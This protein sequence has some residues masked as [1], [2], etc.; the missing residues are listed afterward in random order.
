MCC[1]GFLTGK[2]DLTD[3]SCRNR[4]VSGEPLVTCTT[5]RV[6][7]LDYKVITSTDGIVCEKNLAFDLKDVKPTLAATDVACQGVQYKEC[8]L[9]GVQ[10][11]CFPTRMMAV[12]CQINK[13]YI[14]MRR[15]QIQR[16]VGDN[17][18]PKVEQWLG[19]EA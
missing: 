1:N 9:N 19:C 6:D 4:T 10:G 2:C 5:Q 7:P 17:C 12:S 8:A 13:N 14:A 16:R 3:F 11:M 15:L 18:D